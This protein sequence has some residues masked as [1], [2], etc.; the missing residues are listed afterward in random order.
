LKFS[1]PSTPIFCT[2]KRLHFKVQTYF[3]NHESKYKTPSPVLTG[4]FLFKKRIEAP[5]R[6]SLILPC[7]N[8]AAPLTCDNLTELSGKVFA[9]RNIKAGMDG[10]GLH[11]PCRSSLL[12]N[13]T[14][15][16]VHH[17]YENPFYYCVDQDLGFITLMKDSFTAAASSFGLH[18]P[19]EALFYCCLY[20]VL[21]F[22]AQM[23][24]C[25]IGAGI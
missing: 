19:D 9:L 11:G 6:K 14:R 1:H 2:K 4:P 16:G 23:K 8:W 18:N 3:I 15:F 5:F 17:P 10:L 12:M 20:L 21:G 22:I 7:N 13:G 24:H 25:F